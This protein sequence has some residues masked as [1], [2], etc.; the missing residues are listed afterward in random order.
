LV[1]N[2]SSDKSVVQNNTLWLTL[3]HTLSPVLEVENFMKR[4]ASQK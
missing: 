3:Q 4:N 1:Y 2:H